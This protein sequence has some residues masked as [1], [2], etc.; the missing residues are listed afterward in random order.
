MSSVDTTLITNILNAALCVVFLF[1]ALRAFSLYVQVRSTRLFILGL[2]M[3]LIALTAG[4]D[5]ASGV[6][7]A[8][9]LNTDWFLF[10][11][12]AVSLMFLYLSLLLND[13]QQLRTL[14][15]WHVIVSALLL[16]LLLYS[17]I[18][19]AFPSPLVQFLLS[20]SRGVICL[21]IFFYYVATFMT[22]ETRFGFLMMLTFLLLSF[23]YLVIQ[24]KYF[25]PHQE[26]LDHTGD[27]LR[28]L[29]VVTLSAGFISG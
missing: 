20:G 3:G 27:V 10:I 6:V 16:L 11:G 29:G 22:K 24:P 21:V 8:V 2:S 7:T 9:Q 18:L 23:G 26:L 1:I 19:P 15:G 28:I 13:D 5:F 12:Q 14:L 4:A 25:L 17:P